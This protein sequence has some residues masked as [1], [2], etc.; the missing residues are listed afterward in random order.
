MKVEFVRINLLCLIFKSQVPKL[1]YSKYFHVQ[2]PRDVVHITEFCIIQHCMS[3]LH[4][5]LIVH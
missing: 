3:F 4:S 1:K 2:R 5:L